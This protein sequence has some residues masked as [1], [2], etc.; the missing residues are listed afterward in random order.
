MFKK[1]LKVAIIGKLD[2]KF[3]A[4]FYDKSYQIWGC[5]KHK[6]MRLIPRYDLWF[7]LHDK[8]TNR[9]N[10]LD[11]KPL[12]T[13][14]E[15][16]YKQIIKMLGGLRFNNSM[17]MMIAYAIYKGAKE[18]RLYGCRFENDIENRTK[19]RANVVNMLFFA[20]GKG[21]KV[22]CYDNLIKEYELYK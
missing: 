21:I 22:Y 4:P 20:M 12:I 3:Y 2:T 10:K 5:N 13:C 19:Q 14:D 11:L 18:I 9:F 17:S 1:P 8:N 6:D 15:Y 16:P 7:D